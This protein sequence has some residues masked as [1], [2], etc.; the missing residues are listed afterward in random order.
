MRKLLFL[1]E[2]RNGMDMESAEQPLL[3]VEIEE[4][5]YEEGHP[6][7]RRIAFRVYA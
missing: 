3:D 4:A 6:K 7:I 1:G 2:E 5:G